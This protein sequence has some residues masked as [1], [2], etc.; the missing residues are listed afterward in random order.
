MKLDKA[1]YEQL[2]ADIEKA[3][4]FEDLMGKGGA[5]KK[6]LGV[7]VEKMLEAEMTEHLGYDKHSALGTNSGNSRN[8]KTSKTIQT[9]NG[10]I[11]IGVPRDRNGEFDPI[12]VKKHQRRLGDIEEKIISMYA[13]GMTTRDIQSH[14]EEIYG[15][16]ISASTISQITDTLVGLIQEWQARPLEG[17]YPIVFFDAI[18]Y[19][20]RDEG[21]VVSKAAYTCLGLTIEGKKDLLGIWVGEAE[22]AK[23]WLSILTELRN[24]GVQDILIACVDGLNGFPEAIQTI[25]PQTEV[26][27]CVIHQL[28]NTLRYLATKD[29]K[30]FMQEIR[31][32]YTAPTA[33]NGLY[34][35]DQLDQKW[36]KKYPIII[37]SWRQNWDNLSTFFNYPPELRKIIYTTNAV[38]GLHR[39]FRKVTK[40]RSLFPHDDA[41]SKML[42]LA[43]RDIRKKWTVSVP[44][45]AL[46]ISHLSVMYEKRVSPYL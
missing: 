13:K 31:S 8:G 1:V 46:V 19:K 34:E 37:K 42:F 41:L 23:F 45:W 29:S 43:Y 4:T 6:L 33:E 16:E 15:L 5:I 14:M 3:K 25:F 18:H 30:A 12:V 17:L 44:N 21:H 36:G 27:L 24:R 10:P 9:D 40:T 28:R 35:L 38:E 2:A 22:G 20:V 7:T 39:Q 32:V 11:D 26:Q